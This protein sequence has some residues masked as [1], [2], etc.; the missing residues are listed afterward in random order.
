MHLIFATIA[1]FQF[2]QKKNRKNVELFINHSNGDIEE[3]H[4]NRLPIADQADSH[5]GISILLHI[6]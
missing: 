2:E 1:D 5:D 4:I 3:N 6:G